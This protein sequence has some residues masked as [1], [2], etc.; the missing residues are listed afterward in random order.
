[1]IR[2]EIRTANAAFSGDDYGAEVARILRELAARL[3]G[4][5]AL[6]AGSVILLRDVN[7]NTVG[8]MEVRT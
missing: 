4:H 6:Q 3:E 2:I 5:S 7:G 1:M 8:R